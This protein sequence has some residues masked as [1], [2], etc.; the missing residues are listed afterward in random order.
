MTGVIVGCNLLV[1]VQLG[2]LGRFGRLIYS[3]GKLMRMML[4]QLVLDRCW[5]RLSR[6]RTL[7]CEAYHQGLPSDSSC[8]NGY[9]ISEPD[10]LVING[11]ISL[12]VAAAVG[13][14]YFETQYSKLNVRAGRQPMSN[15]QG[16]AKLGLASHDIIASHQT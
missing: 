5:Q 15:Q 1:G 12:V 14:Q 3:I 10:R 7:L 11:S 8:I 9:S 2:Q 13:T 4:T 6:Y 16:K